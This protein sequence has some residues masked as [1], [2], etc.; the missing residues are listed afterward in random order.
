MKNITI[1]VNTLQ[2]G[3]AER[4]SIYLLNALSDNYKINL[5]VFYCERIEDKLIKLIKGGNYNLIKLEG[6]SLIKIFHLYTIFKTKQI[7]HLFAYLTKPNF[8]GAI[9]GRLAGI[10]YIYT[11]IRTSK[12]PYWKILLE[13]ISSN[14]LATATI[15]NSHSGAGIFRGK[16]IKKRI[17]IPNCFPEIASFFRREQKQIIKIIS[18]GRFVEEKDFFT[19]IRAIKELRANRN[20]CIFQIVGYGPL[21]NKIRSKIKELKLEDTVEIFINPNNIEELLKEADIY[22][23]TSLFEGTSNSI[24]EAMNASLPIVATNVGDNNRLVSEGENGF[25]HNV[26]DYAGI[27]ESLK[28]LIDDYE[29]RMKFGF[30]SNKILRENYFYDDFKD[31]YLKILEQE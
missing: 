7:T 14:Y 19:A 29:K 22:L 1:L 4:Q 10:K 12:L 5:I 16:G 9:I 15:F 27:A 30:A 25:L 2:S 24:M 11:N 20:G 21:E 13:K 8:Y 31:R 26:G 3:G 28:L 23:S 17:V 6:H 18:V